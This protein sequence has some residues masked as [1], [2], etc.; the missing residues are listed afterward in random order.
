MTSTKPPA[1]PTV[2]FT[3]TLR[4]H[5]KTATGIVVPAD[6]VAQLG[7]GKRPPVWVTIGPHTYRSTVAVMGGQ[8]MI[9][10]SA[11]NRDKA[12][13][14]AGDQLD[15]E[16]RLDDDARVAVVPHD[17]AKAL[18]AEPVAQ[19]FFSGLTH[20]QQQWHIHSIESAKTAATRE[21][22]IVRSIGSLLD[23]QAR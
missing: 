22:R 15:V 18:A 23:G 16:L 13:V 7:K 11:G 20:S 19:R 21:R 14:R 9:G 8:F 4:A 12:G 6:L 1:T 3:T 10:V 17:L 2:R 5:G